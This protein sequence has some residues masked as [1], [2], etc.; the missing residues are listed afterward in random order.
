MT[1]G[2]PSTF[3]RLAGCNLR[4]TWCDTRYTWD[5][6][7]F[8]PKQEILTLDAEVVLRQVEIQGPRNVVITG[9]EPLLQQSELANLASELKRAGFR[10]E[11]ETNGTILPTALSAMVDQWNVSPK[12]ESSGN[13]LVEREVEGALDWF[14]RCP[15]AYFKFVVVQPD[16]VDAAMALAGRYSVP[17]DRVVLMPEGTDAFTLAERSRWLI[18]RCCDLG[19]RY[20]TRLH[21]LLWGPERG[22]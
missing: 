11:V 19:V 16:D 7:Q 2:L 14:S 4:C 9:G 21:I 22:R 3:V 10:I 13:A 18:D 15:S 8:N 5:W 12:L 6:A 17:N 20:S 1:A